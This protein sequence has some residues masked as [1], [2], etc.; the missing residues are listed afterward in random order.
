VI[1]RVALACVLVCSAIGAAGADERV[2]NFLSDVTVERSGDLVVT[3]AIS[4]QSEGKQIVY[5]I[6]RDFRTRYGRM[7]GVSVEVRL[8]VQSVTH[9]GKHEEDWIIQAIPDGM[10]V[11]I[12][13]NERRLDP[14][15]HDY[16]IRYRTTRRVAFL[17][18]SDALFW[19]APGSGWTFPFDRAEARI[20][21]PE[22]ASIETVRFYTGTDDE[23]GSNAMI[24]AQEAR[25]LVVRT[26]KPL[27]PG[28]G[29]MVAV[30]WQKGVV[31]PENRPGDNP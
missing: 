30:T 27:P 31:A 16:V 4:V 9:N 22:P 11:R 17:S 21:L 14:G 29:L 3:E 1:A 8:D 6:R 24:V 26:A 15:R 25:R 19:R 7:D 12:G 20:T 5:G 28:N 23:R 2:L 18:N 10:R 13:S